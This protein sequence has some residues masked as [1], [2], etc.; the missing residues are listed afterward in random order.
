MG[1]WGMSHA[2]AEDDKDWHQKVKEILKQAQENDW[3]ITIV[4]CHI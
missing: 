2:T 3:E 4:D 1:W